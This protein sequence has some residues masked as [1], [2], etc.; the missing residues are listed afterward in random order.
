MARNI[1]T[2]YQDILNQKALQPDLAEIDT[3]SRTGIFN[4][5]AYIVAATIWT[6]ENLFDFHKAEV[7]EIIATKTPHR[8]RWYRDK[9]LAFQYGQNLKPDTEIYENIGLSPA[10]IQAQKTVTQAAVTEIDGKL[11]I[12]VAKGVEL[13]E[14]TPPELLA[15]TNYISKIKDAG[16]KI[17]C[18]SLPPDDLKLIIDIWYNPLVLL[19]NGQRIDAESVNPVK[20]AI[21]AYLKNLPFNGEYANTKLVDALQAVDGVVYPHILS[22]QAKYGLFPYTEIDEKYIP[23][24]GYLRLPPDS[25]LVNYIVNFMPY[26]Q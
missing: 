13:T 25:D 23:D 7:D 10:Q 3:T 21:K 26:V 17:I 11:R 5:V 8:L 18:D 6:L 1:N 24:A 15:F 19:P 9:A 22:A 16:V 4:L 20:D 12:K 14:L 2:I